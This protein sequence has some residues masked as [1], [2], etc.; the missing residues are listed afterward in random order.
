ML[1]LFE[2]KKTPIISNL[3]KELESDFINTKVGILPYNKKDSL[4]SNEINE[5][6]G[7]TRH[8][9]PGNKE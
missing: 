3:P 1:N 2:N 8:C 6:V 7:E 5:K 9:P 4:L